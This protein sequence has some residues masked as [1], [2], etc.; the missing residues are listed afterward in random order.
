M[1][2]VEI[3]S[4][5]VFQIHQ[6]CPPQVDS[7]PEFLGGFIPYGTL[8]FLLF[9][10]PEQFTF[11]KIRLRLDIPGFPHGCKLIKA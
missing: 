1:A 2:V 3:S 6:I 7:T 4:L 9:L 5:T 8:P 11:S 10:M